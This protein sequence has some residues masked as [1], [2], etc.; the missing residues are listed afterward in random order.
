MKKVFM[1]V[2]VVAM[3]IAVAAC[4]NN[5]SKKADEVE[6][7]IEENVEAATDSTVAAIDSLE[8]AAQE[9]A[10]EVVAE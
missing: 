2:A 9:I 1:P 6:T 8:A 3:M 10:E 5:N 4:G 7:V